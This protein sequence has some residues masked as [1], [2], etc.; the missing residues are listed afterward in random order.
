MSIYTFAFSYKN[1]DYTSQYCGYS[2]EEALKKWYTT[3][4][5]NVKKMKEKHKKAV[6]AEIEGEHETPTPLKGLDNV[7]HMCFLSGHTFMQLMIVKTMPET[8]TCGS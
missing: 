3:E 5:D 1:G 6:V 8:K 7:W 4:F 2:V